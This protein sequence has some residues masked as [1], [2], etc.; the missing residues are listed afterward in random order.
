MLLRFERHYSTIV[1]PLPKRRTYTEYAREYL[2]V[3]KRQG[4]VE[5]KVSSRNEEILHSYL[6]L[7]IIRV[8]KSKRI[9]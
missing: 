4:H 3:R 6:T 8:I 2:D 9:I 7:N 5:V 1:I